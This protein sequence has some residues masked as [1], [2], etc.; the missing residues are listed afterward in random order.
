[1]FPINDILLLYQEVFQSVPPLLYTA[2][3]AYLFEDAS[4]TYKYKFLE[5][6][7]D[8]F[9]NKSQDFLSKETHYK[10]NVTLLEDRLTAKD[11]L[12][13][14]LEDDIV[15]LE[16]SFKNEEIKKHHEIES[17]NER[18]ENASIELANNKIEINNLLIENQNKVEEYDK[19]ILSKDNEMQDDKRKIDKLKQEKLNL[20]KIVQQLADLSNPSLT[21]TG[22]IEDLEYEEVPQIPTPT[23]CQNTNEFVN[24]DVNE[25]SDQN[26]GLDDDD[27]YEEGSTS[28]ENFSESFET[29]E[30]EDQLLKK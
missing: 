19:I 8:T 25:S 18:I 22:T 11:L 28:V 23:C 5:I 13:A 14:K 27:Y 15:Q 12:I 24:Y 2:F 16:K 6:I 20:L 7:I 10:K 4:A 3:H 17:L 1:M 30:A 9:K 26:Q 29:N 21:F